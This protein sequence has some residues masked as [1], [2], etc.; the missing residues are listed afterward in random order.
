MISGKTSRKIFSISNEEPIIGH[1][2]L[3]LLGIL[4]K[5]GL[6]EARKVSQLGNKANTIYLITPIGKQLL[7]EIKES[8]WLVMV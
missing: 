2:E 3:G 6:V 1:T 4:R 7:E 8:K 5:A